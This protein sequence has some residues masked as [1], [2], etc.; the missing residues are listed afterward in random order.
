MSEGA[1]SQSQAAA[2]LKQGGASAKIEE[3]LTLAKNQKAKALE[4]L[5]EKVLSN[6]LIYVFG[7]FLSQPNFQELGPSNKHLATLELF[8]YDTYTTYKEKR[9]S[10][11]ELSPAQLK[12]L[13]MITIAQAAQKDK[14]LNYSNIAQQIDMPAAN[15]RELEDLIIDCI[16]NELLNG[17]LD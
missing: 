17:K 4:T 5:I 3:F 7:E 2:I 13:K 1:S 8:A 6:P 12:K 15:V 10:Y 11:I 9:A 14:V 16:Y